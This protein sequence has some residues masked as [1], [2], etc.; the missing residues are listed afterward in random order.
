[1]RPDHFVYDGVDSRDFGIFLF[2]LD[3]F[4]AGAR[5]YESLDIPGK[6]GSVLIDG[7]RYPNRAH[8]YTCIIKDDAV[9]NLS[10]FRAFLLSRQGYC[11]LEDSI[12]L[13]EYY[14]AIFREDFSPVLSSDRKM[15]KFQLTFERKPQRWLKSGEQV[16]TLSSDELEETGAKILNPTRFSALPL[17]MFYGLSQ[18]VWFN[19]IKVTTHV[20]P[21]ASTYL[22]C[23]TMEA[24]RMSGGEVTESCNYDIEF[25]DNQIPFLAP[26][27]NTIRYSDDYPSSYYITIIPRWF[28]M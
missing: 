3:T 26:G 24:Y 14:Q 9:K 15:V 17:I 23:E 18:I 11:R 2:D 7:K 19:D 28:T 25:S 21:I 5:E 22:D 27:E 16:I 12:H 4:G 20:S 6:S 1:M 13:D 10:A 8:A